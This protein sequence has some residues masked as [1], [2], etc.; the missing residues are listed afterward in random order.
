MRLQDKAIIVTGAAGGLG[1]QYAIRFAKEGAKL[2]IADVQDV[3]KTAELCRA[4]GAEVDPAARRRLLRGRHAGDGAP[5]PRAVR[6]HRRPPEQRGHDA[7]AGGEVH[8]RRGH[9]DL[10][11][12]RS[13]S[14]RAGRSWACAPSSRTCGSSAPGPSSTSAPAARS[15]SRGRTDR[16]EPAL[17]LVEVGHHRH[18][19][20]RGARTRPVQ[21]QRRHRRAGLDDLRY[22]RSRSSAD[23]AYPMSRRRRS[24]GA[25]CR[26]T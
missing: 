17:R 14:T 19:P 3:S 6:A 5:H 26:R 15:A 22:A 13:R 25:A 11:P 21:H 23:E 8:P 18:H 10:G 9:G 24:C 1:R 20:R 2:T 7:R 4:E 12:R 16:H